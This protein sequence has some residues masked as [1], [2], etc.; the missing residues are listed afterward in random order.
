M[1]DVE[2]EHMIRDLTFTSIQ[3]TCSGNILCSVRIMR[4]ITHSTCF[5]GPY[6]CD[7]HWLTDMP[8]RFKWSS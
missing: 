7:F 6:K 4:S 2:V 5:V 1:E 3:Q 8:C